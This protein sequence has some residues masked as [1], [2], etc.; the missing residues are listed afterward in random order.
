MGTDT[1]YLIFFLKWPK[2][3]RNR[4][5]ILEISYGFRDANVQYGA[6][7]NLSGPSPTSWELPRE[8]RK[9]MLCL[10]HAQQTHLIPQ[11]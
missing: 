6:I 3:W 2:F 1:L 10:C 7:L 5:I 8:E 11:L 4:Y 9:E